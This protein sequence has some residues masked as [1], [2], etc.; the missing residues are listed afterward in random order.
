MLLTMADGS[1]WT[2]LQQ[3]RGVATRLHVIA[4]L[5]EPSAPVGARAVRAGA[6]SVLFRE[7]TAEALRRTVAAAID[8]QAVLPADVVDALRS[9]PA[10]GPDG[11]APLSAEQMSWLRHLAAGM[12]VAQ[13]A[14]IAGY[15][16][17]AMFR[18]LQSLYRRLGVRTRIEAIVHAQERGWLESAV[19]PRKPP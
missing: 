10:H 16:E 17:R 14:R 6:S 13:L 7:M 19:G 18:L 11:D 4:V 15:S 2:L 3:L 12:T 9:G 1:D 8:G 5:A